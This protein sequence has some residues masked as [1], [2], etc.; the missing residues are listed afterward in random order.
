MI[1]GVIVGIMI[2]RNGMEVNED[3]RLYGPWMASAVNA[4]TIFV[5]QF[6][7]DILIRWITACLRTERKR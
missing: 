5:F 2:I 7:T 1:T 6:L 4:A 3:L